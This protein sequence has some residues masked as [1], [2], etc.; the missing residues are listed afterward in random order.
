[1]KVLSILM[2]LTLIEIP[3]S[4]EAQETGREYYNLDHALTDPTIVELDYEDIQK[5][6]DCFTCF[7]NIAENFETHKHCA[8][9][10]SAR[11][12]NQ[13]I[14]TCQEA[15]WKDRLGWTLKHLRAQHKA[16]M[17]LSE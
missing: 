2:L 1:M 9:P 3:L 4:G 7:W 8:D 10:D 12:L 16:C 14:I 15:P 11:Y 5:V 6:D 13:C 17:E